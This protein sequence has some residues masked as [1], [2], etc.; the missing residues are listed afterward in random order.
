M[1]KRIRKSAAMLLLS[2]M[3]SACN[4]GS[5]GNGGNGDTPQQPESS[6]PPSSTGETA[7]PAALPYEAPLTGI[8]LE[9]TADARP[10]VVMINNFAA[11]RPQSGLTNADVIWEVLAEGGITRLIAVF[12]STSALTETIGP[13]RSIR[14]YLIDIGDSYGAVLAHAGASNDGYA[15]LQRQGKPYLDEISNAGSYFW[16]SKDRKAPHN[17]YSSLEQ[18]RTG[19]EKKKYSLDKQVPP[20]TFAEAGSTEAGVAASDITISFLLKNYNVGYLYDAAS[21]LYKRSISG[22]PHIDMNNN[23]QLSGTNLVVLGADHKTLDNEGRLAVDLTSG[24]SAIL[25]QRGKAVEAE[26]VRAPDGMI[27]IIKNGAE[28]PFVPGKTFF[29]IVPNKP[30][31]ESHVSWVQT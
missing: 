13:V 1:D 27:R 7:Q 9:K 26:W 12:Q 8:K 6:T 14:P 4:G 19:A 22:K 21:G 2:L 10:I 24:G 17:L 23:E 25:F 29:H 30:T 5:G 15:I 20:Y 31:F 16:R 18:L 3:L 11:A 28:L